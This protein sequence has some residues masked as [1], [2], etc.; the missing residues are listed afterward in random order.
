MTIISLA[1]MFQ[2]ADLGIASG[3]LTTLARALAAIDAN[4]ARR[5]VSSAFF[6]S[7]LI[8]AF[9]GPLI[10]L[11]VYT[12]SPTSFLNLSDRLA[13]EATRAI[14]VLV[15]CSVVNIPLGLSQQIQLASQRGFMNGL[16]SVSASILAIAGI[17]LA[18]TLRASPAW[19]VFAVSAPTILANA[20]NLI[21]LRFQKENLLPKVQYIGID[22]V[23]TL[24]RLG[25][26]F[27]VIQVC[28]V[29]SY[30][31]DNLILA[32]QM[33]TESVAVYST[34]HKLF[35]QTPL[36]FGFVLLPLWPAYGNAIASG[37]IKWVRRT[38]RRTMLLGAAINIPV[39]ILLVAFG[40]NVLELWVGPEIQAPFA[41]LLG[42][43]TW[44]ALNCFNGPLA[45]LLNAMGVMRFQALC[46]SGMAIANVSLTFF[47]IERIGISGPIYASILSQIVFV[48]V[49]ALFYVPRLLRNL[50]N[51]ADELSIPGKHPG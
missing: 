13:S 24:F 25:P 21:S 41:L 20:G 37:D 27:L 51:G 36:L 15:C 18:V 17:L 49:P 42:L 6:L 28:G 33:G 50:G 16:W 44:A 14:V 8:A 48:Y 7:A 2:L 31:S 30:Y 40:N 32:M 12:F 35:F 10:V 23:K 34:A 45:A 29:A 43:G 46:T 38:F 9:L 19:L 5:L 39:A 26:L 1:S 47:L 3:L 4:G 11:G 22:E